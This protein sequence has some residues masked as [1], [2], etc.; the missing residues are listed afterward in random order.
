RPFISTAR[1]CLS[2]KVSMAMPS[3]QKDL[4]LRFDH[5]FKINPDESR[6]Q[7]TP[8]EILAQEFFK[9]DKDLGACN[10]QL[11]LN[12]LHLDRMEGSATVVH[13]ACDVA[14]A[15]FLMQPRVGDDDKLGAVASETGV[16]R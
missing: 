5:L 11:T 14:A 7:Q 4:G 12:G 6:A 8:R 9:G 3:R 15:R 2:E 1:F 10:M 13:E 16:S